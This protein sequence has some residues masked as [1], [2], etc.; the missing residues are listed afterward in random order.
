MSEQYD[1]II[2]GS[3]AGGLSAGITAKLAGLRPL[4][5]EKTPLIGGSSSLSGGVLWLPDN[6]LMK[7]DGIADSREA[8]LR[9]M[10]NFVQEGDPA[11]TPARREAYVDTIDP[12]LKSLEDQGMKYLRCPGYAD[13]YDHLPGGH[14]DRALQAELFDISR[15][16][17][18]KNKL[19][20]PGVPLPVRTGEGAK[21]MRVGITMDGKVMMAK[22][23][24]RIVKNKLTG[25]TVYGSGG[26]LQ[27]RMLEIA[28]R[29]GVE[30][31]TDAALQELDIVDGRVEGV[32]IIHEGVQKT[33]KAGR[34]VLVTT[35]GFSRNAEM[36]HKYQREPATTEWTQANPGDTGDGINAMQQAGAALGWMDESWWVMG[37]PAGG[38]NLPVVPELIKPHGILVDASGQRFVNEARSYME[39]GTT[40]Y[41]RNETVKAIPAWC[42][43]DSQH[44]KR[45]MFAMKPP[46]RIPKEWVEKEWVYTD[47]SIAGLARKCGVDPAGLEATVQ[48]F[49]GFCETGIDTDFHRGDNA[50][51]QYWADPTC[52]PNGS[53]GKIE[54]GPFWAAPLVPGDV[55]TCGGVIT[56]PSARVLRED[57]SVIE[58]LYAAGNCAAPLAGG[59]YIGA[60][61]SIGASSVFGYIAAKHAAL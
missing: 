6:L 28:L 56:D 34:G 9:Y 29:L 16:G 14:T 42:I 58:G 8:A 4:I 23:V 1:L 5:L 61:L 50:Y 27:G 3:G 25:K 52:K 21:L 57:G 32:H 36:R 20:P 12:M 18:W 10:A 26:A 19:R 30:I 40:C 59:N 44:R 35:G 2:V 51:A 22:L 13:Y 53:L 24:G 39:V 38:Q 11:S 54:K 55:G 31:W 49:N 43:M 46:G 33:L 7:R 60:G 45:Y 48:R 41:A 15:L 17:S 47:D 37:F